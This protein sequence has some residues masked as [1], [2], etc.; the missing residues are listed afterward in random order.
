[1]R[2]FDRQHY[3]VTHWV[4]EN[5][6]HQVIP[7]GCEVCH[8]CDNPPCI[9]PD[10]LFIGTRKDN[11]Q[12]AAVKGRMKHGIKSNWSKLTEAEVKEIRKSHLPN[13]VLASK[14]GVH[15]CTVKRVKLFKTY[16][17]ICH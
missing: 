14:H 3:L 7:E 11:L 6:K 1:M 9:N 16:R 10:H 13:D 8:R 12:D 2:Y 4:V 17:F 15:E 5:V